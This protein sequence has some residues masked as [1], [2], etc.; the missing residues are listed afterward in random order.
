MKRFFCFLLSLFIVFSCVS[1]T[2]RNTLVKKVVWTGNLEFCCFLKDDIP[3]Y[4]KLYFITITAN[5]YFE[6]P[7]AKELL[8]KIDNESYFNLLSRNSTDCY[9]RQFFINEYGNQIKAI[10]LYYLT[11][12]T[13][14][15]RND[16]VFLWNPEIYVH[17]IK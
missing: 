1:C 2:S 3:V 10:R 8:K 15:T 17:L 16:Y 4:R 12:P 7:S 5:N 11:E 14:E 9:N 6:K 13:F